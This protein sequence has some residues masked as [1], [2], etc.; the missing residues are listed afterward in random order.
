MN[1]TQMG[2]AKIKGLDGD[3]TKVSAERA[4]IHN[5]Y[6]HIT[7]STAK[8]ASQREFHDAPFCYNFDIS[9]RTREQREFNDGLRSRVEGLRPAG[10]CAVNPT[11]GTAGATPNLIANTGRYAM[12]AW[13]TT[14]PFALD[15]GLKKLYE[16]GRN[17]PY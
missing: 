3:E 2:G 11:M 12:D 14:A 16:R 6:L 13:R 15:H 17:D 1:T 5:D 7:R 9:Q 10:L 4:Q 8:K